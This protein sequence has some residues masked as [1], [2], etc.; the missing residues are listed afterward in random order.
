MAP[1]HC[2][3]LVDMSESTFSSRCRFGSCLPTFLI[4]SCSGVIFSSSSIFENSRHTRHR[5]H[6]IRNLT[7]NTHLAPYHSSWQVAT[8]PL[9]SPAKLKQGPGGYNKPMLL[10]EA[11]KGFYLRRTT[12]QVYGL[13]IVV[14]VGVLLI[15]CPIQGQ[16]TDI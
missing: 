9:R 3:I 2:T 6:K 5:K 10:L 8:Y 13:T 11:V 1:R 14:V 16:L 4:A 15:I 12:T 7:V